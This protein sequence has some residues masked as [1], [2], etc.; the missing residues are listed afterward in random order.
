MET[1]MG[2]PKSRS[3]SLPPLKNQPRN[4]ARTKENDAWGVW[5]C[6]IHQVFH[7]MR[8]EFLIPA[9]KSCPKSAEGFST[10]IRALHEVLP[11]RKR[12]KKKTTSKMTLKQ[13]LCMERGSKGIFIFPFSPPFGG[14]KE[15]GKGCK[16]WQKK[17]VFYT[18]LIKMTSSH[19]RIR[20]I[21]TTHRDIFS[22]ILTVNDAILRSTSTSPALAS[23]NQNQMAPRD[24]K[25][26][27]QNKKKTQFLPGKQKKK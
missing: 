9:G 11:S 3:H 7:F 6:L 22:W 20:G 21:K 12:K 8:M 13:E 24:P 4:N 5:K 10:W 17:K 2:H 14:W 23:L 18:N 26:T 27:K 15:V 16:K 1:S 19:S 25:G